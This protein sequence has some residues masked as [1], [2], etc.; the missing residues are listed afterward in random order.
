MRIFHFSKKK[1]K[2]SNTHVMNEYA[3]NIM[4]NLFFYS[5]AALSLS[6]YEAVLSFQFLFRNTI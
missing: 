4:N 3:L 5:H 1:M 6:S 2:N